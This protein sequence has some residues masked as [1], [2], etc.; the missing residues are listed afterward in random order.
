[1][2]NGLGKIAIEHD[3]KLLPGHNPV[4]CAAARL[5]FK[6]QD[7]VYRK[8]DQMIEDGAVAPISEPTEWVS[9]MV[10]TAKPDGHVRNYIGQSELNN[11]V[12]R[13]HFIIDEGR[14]TIQ[15]NR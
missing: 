7:K 2:F 13:E 8:L 9:R 12:R 14:G 10:V 1:M 11:A 5:P 15:Q 4:V 6:L 3:I